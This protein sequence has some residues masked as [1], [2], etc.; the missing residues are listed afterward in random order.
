MILTTHIQASQKT[1][2][3]TKVNPL[4][5]HIQ[6]KAPPENNRAN[7]AIQKIISQELGLPLKHITL[8]RGHTSRLK[9]WQIEP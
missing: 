3:V 5:W 9:L 8:K 6:V 7:F 1:T 2:S 4:L